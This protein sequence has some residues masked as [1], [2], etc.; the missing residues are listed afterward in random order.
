MVSFSAENEKAELQRQIAE[1]RTQVDAA[2]EKDAKIKELENTITEWQ[3][4]WNDME[5]KVKARGIEL[6]KTINSLKDEKSKLELFSHWAP[7]TYITSAGN[8]GNALV[9]GR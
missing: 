4:K 7:K 9:S 8:V 3:Q 2:K 1:L 5:V 6:N